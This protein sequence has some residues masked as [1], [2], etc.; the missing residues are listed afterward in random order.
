[1]PWRR[2]IHPNTWL[3]LLFAIFAAVLPKSSN[4]W[5]IHMAMTTT[6]QA[7]PHSAK[8]P[9]TDPWGISNRAQIS[10]AA[11]PTPSI[12]TSH[13]IFKFAFYDSLA[14]KLSKASIS[15]AKNLI[16]AWY[17][18]CRS[19]SI[20]KNFSLPR[21]GRAQSHNQ[22]HGCISHNGFDESLEAV[23][24]RP[25]PFTP[26]LSHKRKWGHLRL[27]P[28]PPQRAVTARHRPRRSRAG[29][30]GRPRAGRSRS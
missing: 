11:P 9:A 13:F 24:E 20:K 23:S 17:R 26:S 14:K 30:G 21:C 12:T 22:K 8:I 10:I 15:H 3:R 16:R 27:N 29:C 4:A 5:P 1:M 7:K 19:E 2:W 6:R 25:V 18:T 28:I